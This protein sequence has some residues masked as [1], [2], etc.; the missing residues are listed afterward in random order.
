MSSS[1]AGLSPTSLGLS[2]R[3]VWEISNTALVMVFA[4]MRT[5]T[6]GAACEF[7]RAVNILQ[8]T[9][10]SVCSD[11][12]R[13][14]R[15]VFV[16][17]VFASTSFE[18]SSSCGLR[19]SWSGKANTYCKD[20]SCEFREADKESLILEVSLKCT[21]RDSFLLV[22]QSLRNGRGCETVGEPRLE[23]N[24]DGRTFHEIS[25]PIA[26]PCVNH[27]SCWKTGNFL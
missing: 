8:S 21:Q 2:H 4:R 26:L 3:R 10:Q 6:I 22:L 12:R 17:L 11:S 15:L 1:L 13:M 27:R 18:P 23:E 24:L 19:L 20:R 9:G 25:C 7:T 16:V 14:T 5:L